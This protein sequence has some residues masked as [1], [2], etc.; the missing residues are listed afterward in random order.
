M[1]HQIERAYEKAEEKA[2]RESLAQSFEDLSNAIQEME[3]EYRELIEKHKSAIIECDL[4]Q[5]T[6]QL[7]YDI[8]KIGELI[9]E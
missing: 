9:P 5:K 3:D 7:K 2:E 8:T 4:T 6:D 1:E